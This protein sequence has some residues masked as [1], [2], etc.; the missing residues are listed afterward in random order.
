M[1]T[2]EKSPDWDDFRMVQAVAETGS[3]PAAASRLGLNHSTVFRRLGEIEKRLGTPLFERHRS[4][5]VPT[6]AGE[7][8]AALA[9]RVADDITRL[10]LRLAGKELAPSGEVRIATSDS[11]LADLLMPMLGGIRDAYPQIRLDVVTGNEPLNLSR[12]DA[13]I[14]LRASNAPPDTLVG[15]RI[16]GIA[17]ALFGLAED[18]PLSDE[19][20]SA[21][22]DAAVLATQH[23]VSLGDRMARLKAAQFVAAHVPVGQVVATFD[24]VASLG[25]A[26]EAGLGIGYLPCFVGDT[27]PRLRRLAPPE[28]LFTTDLWLLTHPNLRAAPRI[29]AVLDGLSL[30]LGMQRGVI[31]GTNA[32]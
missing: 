28:P 13:D 23:W 11:L 1:S 2:P 9:A 10:T 25:A 17:W 15:R 19:P 29:R 6:T 31:E 20:L 16:A 26:I 14:A 32:A 30:Q 4:G 8:A 18:E 12:R 3:L 27:S 22:A 21:D 7:E 24:T 5:Y